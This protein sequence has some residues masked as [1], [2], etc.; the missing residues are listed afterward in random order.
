MN[1]A[2]SKIRRQVKATASRVSG[3]HGKRS[4]RFLQ[5][6]AP[7]RFPAKVSSL[8]HLANFW[9]VLVV[10]GCL[11]LLS[12]RSSSISAHSFGVDQRA[13]FPLCHDT[14]AGDPRFGLAVMLALPSNGSRRKRL[15]IVIYARYSTEEQDKSSIVDQIA[16]CKRRLAEMG[17]DGDIEEISDP[18]ISGETLDRPGMNK[19]R[20]GLEERRWDLLVAE[21]SSRLFRAPTH[22]GE[23][24]ETAV[25]EGIRVLCINDFVDTNN[26]D[27]AE[28]LR[29]AQEAHAKA[30][31]YTR[32][33]LKRKREALWEM[34][35]AMGKL[36]P[37]YRRRP[38][39]PASYGEP[40]KGPFFD[41][42]DPALEPV[43]H[44][45]FERV[46]SG[47]KPWSV[48]HWLNTTPLKCDSADGRWEEDHV[49]SLIECEVYKGIEFY[50]KT[51]TT[52]K[53]RKLKKVTRRR[54][55]EEVNRR[56]MEHQRIVPDW[57]WAK[58]NR[59]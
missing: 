21:D 55:P 2:Q 25:D 28:R 29:S 5:P 36:R 43:V 40:A 48:A 6:P 23:L 44:E 7:S 30:N 12:I 42:L 35:A 22:C 47:E 14:V 3:G 33:R 58:A 1:T 17:I 46:A 38:T 39:V 57:I 13:E 16:Y 34:G 4:G 56:L 49:I 50:G 20:Q 19:L 18:E 32:Q 45:A 24:V 41:D 10:T 8:H 31:W 26:E 37:G 53:L 11:G 54:P 52:R 15:R 59:N 9:I 51:K 27:W